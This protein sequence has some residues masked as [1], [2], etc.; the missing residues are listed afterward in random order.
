VRKSG[1]KKPFKPAQPVRTYES[2]V[3]QIEDAIYSGDLQPGDRLPSERDL[4]AQFGVSRASIREA[5]RV[6][7]SS[8]LIRS[9]PGD[10]S[11]G[12]EI[13][14]SS[15]ASLERSLMGLV[16]MEQLKLGVLVEF[17]MVIEGAA[18]YLAAGMRTN[19]DLQAMREAHARMEAEIGRD[20]E[21]FA[22]ADAD[23]HQV[24][25][26]SAGN[27][28]LTACNAVSRGMM[29]K[30]IGDKL[31]MVEDTV[32]LQRETWERHGRVLKAIEEGDPVSAAHRAKLDMV[33][34]YSPFM[35]AKEA[36]RVR[37]LAERAAAA[38]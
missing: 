32:E 23:F 14:P 21:A 31:A 15:S 12:A 24:V 16:R 3:Q 7:A 19:D 38:P 4:V 17:R 26:T 27:E 10:P 8:G 18:T 2:I 36:A 11:G 22:R 20:V 6:L 25:A 30:M 5:L 13:L 9:R 33:E 34:Y 1:H 35:D 37:S 28:L 29:M